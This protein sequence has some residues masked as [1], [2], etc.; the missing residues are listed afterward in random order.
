MKYDKVYLRKR[1][2]YDEMIDEIEFKQPK[3][4]YPNRVAQFL[5]NTS[6]LSQF[7]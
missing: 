1:P 6:Q 7:D 5:R 2:Q 4:K 3:I